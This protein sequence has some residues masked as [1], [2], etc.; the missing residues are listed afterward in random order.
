MQFNMFLQFMKIV[1]TNSAKKI[2]PLSSIIDDKCLKISVKLINTKSNLGENEYL[3][4]SP[5]NWPDFT[6]VKVGVN[7]H[8][9]PSKTTQIPNSLAI[10]LARNKKPPTRF[11]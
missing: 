8:H 10:S 7:Y 6:K 5:V 2:M 11:L 9:S 4:K 3:S 1:G